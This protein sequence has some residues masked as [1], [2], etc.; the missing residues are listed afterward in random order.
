LISE[1][2]QKNQIEEEYHW[3]G[4]RSLKV[5]KKCVLASN[6][7]DNFSFRGSPERRSNFEDCECDRSA[8]DHHSNINESC[9]V[10]EDEY[11]TSN[12]NLKQK[13]VV[14]ST[15]YSIDGKICLIFE[16][17]QRNQIEEVKFLQGRSSV[18]VSHK[19]H[20]VNLTCEAESVNQTRTS[21][22]V[23]CDRDLIIQHRSSDKFRCNSNLKGLLTK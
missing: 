19:Y 23:I 9:L 1:T 15:H 8:I 13:Q 20:S 21:S 22:K 18:I 7:R 16:T 6:N 17:N 12:S 14:E 4:F 2:D 5:R 10:A 11:L 3:Y